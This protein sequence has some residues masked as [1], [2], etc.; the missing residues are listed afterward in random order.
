MVEPT[1]STTGLNDWLLW[2]STVPIS[3][4]AFN[5]PRIRTKVISRQDCMT[6]PALFHQQV[7]LTL[8]MTE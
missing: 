2:D 7:R 8:H 5:K 6:L 1:E 3:K 4:W